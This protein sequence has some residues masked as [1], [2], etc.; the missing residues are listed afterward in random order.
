MPEPIIKYNS[1]NTFLRKKFNNQKIRKIP[2]N[3]DISCPNKDGTISRK[4][5]IFCDEYG[6]GPITGYQLSIEEQIRAYIGGR[7]YMKY[8]AYFQAHSNTS[9]SIDELRKKYNII[10]DFPQI[11]GLFIGTRPDSISPE[12]YP[13]LE[14]LNQKTYL[15]VEL[16]LQ[17]IHAKSLD[18]LHRNHTYEQFLETFNNLRQRN[19][20]VVVHLIVGIPGETRDDI[21]E[22]IQEMNRIKPTGIKFHLMHVLHNTPLYNL[23]QAQKFKL[24]EQGEYVELIIDILE[25]LDPEIIIHRMNGERNKEIYYAPLWATDKNRV[26]LDIQRRMRERDTRQGKYYHS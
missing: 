13:L 5:C 4:G 25:R 3:A 12:A 11:V 14:E 1:F 17:S 24:L 18:F 23:Y 8:L 10:F 21:L 20:E 19:I 7:T 15:T 26:L 22:T 6:S 16:G 9:A 2:I